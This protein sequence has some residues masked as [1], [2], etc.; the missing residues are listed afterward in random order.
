MNEE[1]YSLVLD[2]LENAGL[3]GEVE[4]VILA[5]CEGPEELANHLGGRGPASIRPSESRRTPIRGIFLKSLEVRGFRGIGEK[6]ILELL[7]GPGLTLVVGRNGSGKSSLAEALE[8]AFTGSNRRWE[9]RG[10]QSHWRDGWRNLHFEGPTE[11]RV[12]IAVEGSAEPGSVAWSWRPGGDLTDGTQSIRADGSGA[13]R[14]DGWREALS[15]YRPFLS[16]NEL[17][18]MLEGRPVDL[19][20]ALS[21]GLGLEE[22]DEV[23]EELR[24][25]RLDYSGRV[26]EARDSLRRI[27]TGLEGLDDPRAR[28]CLE[29]LATPPWDLDELESIAAGTSAAHDEELDRLRRLRALDGPDPERIADLGGRLRRSDGELRAIA[30]SEA[31]KGSGRGRR[32]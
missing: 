15:S 19:Y 1:L 26:K 9:G 24:K 7:E 30:G 6:T 16:Y 29:A 23:Q 27:L 17:G 4:A 5:A 13:D 18:G 28:A 22:L 20:R 14:E 31:E 12:H 25:T 3:P 2:R 8:Y 32:P 21:A 11:I 10:A